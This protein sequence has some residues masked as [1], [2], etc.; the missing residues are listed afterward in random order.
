M[1][2]PGEWGKAPPDL[3]ERFTSAVAAMPGA[4]VRKMFGYPAGFVNG[5]LF[6]GIFESSWFVRLPDDERAQ[7]AAAGGSAFSPM[8]GRPMR[9]YVVMP[10]TVAA[11]PAAAEPWLLRALEHTGQ[12]PPKAKR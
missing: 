2:H 1:P 3:A 10:A 7:L 9:E 6:T 11:D 8:P 4:Q 12:L 5:N